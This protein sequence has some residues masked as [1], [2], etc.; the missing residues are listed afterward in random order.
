MTFVKN[1][2]SK[3]GFTYI[4]VCI[5]TSCCKRDFIVYESGE[6]YINLETGAVELSGTKWSIDLARIAYRKELTN[7]KRANSG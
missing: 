3:N 6:D 2:Y 7:D 5:R 4:Q 1:E